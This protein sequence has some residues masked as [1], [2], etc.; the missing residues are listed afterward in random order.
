MG[1]KCLRAGKVLV[2]L[3]L[4]LWTLSQLNQIFI[5]KSLDKPWDMSNKIGGFYNS[6]EDYDLYFLGTSHSYCSFSPLE[7][8]RETGLK[9]YVLASQQQPLDVTY[10]YMKDAVKKHKPQA[11]VLDVFSCLL[12]E[13]SGDPGIVHSYSD[14]MP[15][16][17]NKLEMVYRV[18]PKDMKAQVVFPLIKYHDRWPDLEERD[19]RVK[20]RDYHDPYRGYVA[21]EGQSQKFKTDLEGGLRGKIAQKVSPKNKETLLRIGNYCA[22]RGIDLVLVKTPTFEDQSYAKALDDLE[23]FIQVQGLDYIN[24]SLEKEAMGLSAQDY[25]DGYH[26]NRQGVDKFSKTLVRDLEKFVDLKKNQ[27]QDPDWVRDLALLEKD[28]G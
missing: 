21:L 12:Q 19:Y 14:D 9:S 23:K 22:K 13:D 24:Y 25:Y 17:L 1:K 20:Y 11:I 16:S 6:Q 27:D 28:K 3:V 26:M 10:Y 15:M 4:V 7:I 8:Y 18:V 5:R 2:F